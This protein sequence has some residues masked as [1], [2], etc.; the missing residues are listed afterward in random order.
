MTRHHVAWIAALGL[1]S[2]ASPAEST[3]Q[4]AIMENQGTQLQ[5]VQLQGTQAQGMTLVGFQYAGATLGG[6]ALDNVHVAEGE[7]VADQGGT[8]L[9]GAALVGAHVW[10]QAHNP[11]NPASTALVEYRITA[12][13]AEAAKY[14]PTSTGGTYVYTLEQNVDGTGSWQSACLADAD[15]KHV[16]IPLTATWDDHGNR[17]ASSSLFTFGCTTGAVAKCYRWGYRPWVTSYGDLAAVHWACTRVARADYCGNGT[18]HTRDG[19][20]INVWD[21][22]PSPGP[23]ETRGTPPLGMLFE[24]GWDTGGAVCFSHARWLLDGPLIALGCPGRLIAPALGILNATVCD[25]IAQVLGQ[26]G[27]VMIF[28]DSNLN[29][30]L[31]LF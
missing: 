20:T 15:G 29:L 12:V 19:T 17:V 3:G 22:L 7:L 14:D 11:A 18:P 24:A 13:E 4:Q 10:A 30:N 28:D 1:A 16:A 2:C 27:D 25:T 26:A 21:G 8:T 23:I 31:D 6:T 5:G 9:H